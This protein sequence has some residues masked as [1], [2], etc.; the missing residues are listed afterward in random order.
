MFAFVCLFIAPPLMATS[1]LL[2][3]DIKISGQVNIDVDR[4]DAF[5]SEDAT[6]STTNVELRQAK[7]SAK[8]ALNTDWKSKLQIKYAYENSDSNRFEIADAFLSYNGFKWAD[9][10]I[11]KMKEPFSLE[12]NMGSSNLSTIERSMATSAFSP[13]RSY[14]VQLLKKRNKYTWGIGYHR[15]ST[16]EAE[17]RALTARAT[18]RPLS[19]DSQI[20]HL[21]AS[22]SFRD[23]KNQSFQIKEN[24]E[25]HTADNIIRSARFE[26]KKA[27]V[28]GF[29]LA[30]QYKS[31]GIQTE[32][33]SNELTQSNGQ[34][35]RYSGSYFQANWFV[36]GERLS[37]RKG[38]FKR[39]TPRSSIG[40]FEVVTRFSELNLRDH[41]LGSH[42]SSYL[43]GI[44]YY[45]TKNYKLMFNYLVPNMSGNSLHAANSGEATSARLHISF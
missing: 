44:N 39:I 32:Y 41:Q 30:W 19:T 33:F 8:Y 18:F 15:D 17:I 36:T 37:Y 10:R 14:G 1:S 42:S 2:D 6:E 45:W 40:A 7:I 35:W 11:G 31:I 9:I 38:Q 20:L 3:N 28:R 29:E 23:R 24:A 34:K 13:A 43:L 25:V 22:A 16:H 5:Y 27:V 4:F 26:L 21:G 12:R